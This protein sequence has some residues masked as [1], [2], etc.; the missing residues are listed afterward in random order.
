[1][2]SN[3]LSKNRRKDNPILFIHP[4]E[5]YSSINNY[6]LLI[7]FMNG[8]IDGWMDLKNIMMNS[9]EAR[10]ERVH[11]IWFLLSEV[12]EQVKLIHG[13]LNQNWEYFW[14]ENLV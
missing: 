13:N 11:T 14:W 12:L 6:K 10:H 8:W 1:M 7:Y 9:H 2:K 3:Q 4:V 5:Y